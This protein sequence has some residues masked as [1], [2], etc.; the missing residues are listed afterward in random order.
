[1]TDS[2][3]QQASLYMT[4]GSSDKEYHAQ[5]VEKDGGWVVN[6]QYGRRG[7][8]LKS[9]TKTASP[10]A[11]V[12]AAKEYDKLIAEKTKKGYTPD[13]S[14]EV[15][16]DTV[17]GA[18]FSGFLPQLPQTV[19]SP[20]DIEAM[21]LDPAFF[22]QEKFDGDNRQ[23]H[24]A[25]TKVRG[26]NKRG[27]VVAL[28]MNLADQV[29]ALPDFLVSGEIIANK[30]YVF[31]LQEVDGVDLRARPYSKRVAEMEEFFAGLADIEVVYTARTVAEKRA[32]IEDVLARAGEGVVFKRANSVFRTGKLSATESDHFKWKFTEDC[33]VRVKKVHATKRS[34][35]VEIDHEDKAVSLGNVPIPVNRDIPSTGDLVSVTYLHLFEGGSLFQAQYKGVRTDCDGPDTMDMFK[36]K[37]KELARKVSVNM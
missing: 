20:G 22:L 3:A 33:T 12:L 19:R 37:P 23:V 24:R 28:P 31:D 36:I 26:I 16:Q 29:A 13:I 17:A 21:I 10:V 5:L 14:G 35:E 32:L 27:I 9:G 18:D 15:F 34:M 25:G 8:A 11:Y 7:K 6:F 2:I 4:E 1:M 30:L